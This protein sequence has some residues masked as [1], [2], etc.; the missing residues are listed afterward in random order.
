MSSDKKPLRV[1]I[2]M[3]SYSGC[4]PEILTQL[5]SVSF[6]LGR[7]TDWEV[8]PFIIGRRRC[9]VACNTAIDLMER[10]EE[11]FPKDERFTHVLWFDD[12]VALSPNSTIR[13]VESIDE[14]HPAVFALAFFRQHP[15]RPSI[16]KYRQWQG[17]DCTLEQIYDYPEDELIRVSAAGLCAAAFDRDVFL[18]L[19]KPYF[20]WK[21][22]GLNRRA[23]TPDGWLCMQLLKQEIPVYCH[24][25]IKTK[26][27]GFPEVVDEELALKYK[28]KWTHEGI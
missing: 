7:R 5:I 8:M 2:C 22:G 10:A 17:Q 3:A 26:H 24:T 19:D 6:A 28:D 21:M 1:A 16:W 23:A 12:D 18:A 13:L 14:Q 9:E 25:G 27:L 4:A 15:Y 20:E 11:Q